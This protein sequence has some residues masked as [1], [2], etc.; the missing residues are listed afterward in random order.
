MLKNA[1]KIKN[2]KKY[3]YFTKLLRGSKPQGFV[4]S[5][6]F[7]RGSVSYE[8]KENN[9][10]IILEPKRERVSSKKRRD[11]PSVTHNF[12]ES[13]ASELLREPGSEES[14]TELRRALESLKPKEKEIS[15]AR[16]TQLEKA[17]DKSFRL[18]QLRKL[19]ESIT[20]NGV[21]KRNKSSLIKYFL[22]DHWKLE[23]KT[24]IAD[25]LVQELDLRVSPVGMFF[26]LL[27][28]A[29]DVKSLSKVHDCHV[30]FNVSD[31]RIRIQGKK[32]AAEH[33]KDNVFK[34]LNQIQVA[35]F[36]FPEYLVSLVKENRKE[37]CQKINAFLEPR[38]KTE[39]KI[40]C[41]L[42]DGRTFEDVERMLYALV[43][44]Y[45][46]GNRFYSVV[47]TNKM[48]S[49]VSL[50]N[51]SFSMPWFTK[52]NNVWKRWMK[53]IGYSW[54]TSIQRSDSLENFSTRLPTLT[55]KSACMSFDD[56]LITPLVAQKD[57]E[58]VPISSFIKEH[59]GDFLIEKE[60]QENFFSNTSSMPIVHS[61]KATFG[62]SLFHSKHFSSKEN[63]LQSVSVTNGTDGS[64][65]NI[66]IPGIPNLLSTL[67]QTLSKEDLLQYE[68]SYIKKLVFTPTT[69][70]KHSNNP[71]Y[72]EMV[73]SS[74]D[75]DNG[76]ERQ[77][78]HLIMGSDRKSQILLPTHFVDL[79]MSSCS[80]QIIPWE[81]SFNDYATR[82]FPY[83]G[84]KQFHKCPKQFLFSSSQGEMQRDFHLQS[85]EKRECK[86]FKWGTLE[87]M[88]SY[89]MSPYFTGTILE[90]EGASSMEDFL[91][92]LWNLV[93][94]YQVP[95]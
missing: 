48:N 82:C 36:Q 89:V 41:I 66:F 53:D 88:C 2:I 87:L 73:F 40:S 15:L 22:Q 8:S 32:K 67:F 3:S 57:N 71:H 72:L 76:L 75:K 64:A 63:E 35:S 60:V 11:V 4:F 37:F 65:H 90:V 51:N 68:T 58:Y 95:N 9:H 10:F 54:N 28:K 93:I 92:N 49:T 16:L 30:F 27:D 14:V 44:G 74:P 24:S 38:S 62:H 45:F 12:V 86:K 17:I 78:K 7:H 77:E 19:F 85:Y 59:E 80:R 6:S 31:Y 91:K 52:N 23:V 50:R 5:R 1:L 56:T 94:L 84:S 25:D 83:L 55:S 29:A 13:M 26:L 81:D 61:L 34:R 79:L 18:Q 39:L 21:G 69:E 47:P 42:E 20:L 33:M 46:C 70:S 43:N